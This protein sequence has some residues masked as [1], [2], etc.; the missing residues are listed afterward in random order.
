MQISFKPTLAT[1]NIRDVMTAAREKW[2]ERDETSHKGS[3]KEGNESIKSSLERVRWPNRRQR[4]SG[5]H[6]NYEQPI[7]LRLKLI[8]RSPEDK[9]MLRWGG[10]WRGDERLPPLPRSIVEIK[11]SVSETPRRLSFH[12]Y[13]PNLLWTA[14]I[15]SSN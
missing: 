14:I 15:T 8:T 3:K 7:I 2:R 11:R 4:K 13:L 12:T 6:L 9:S 1:C 10:R 5:H